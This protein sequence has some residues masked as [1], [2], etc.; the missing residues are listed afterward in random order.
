M[1]HAGVRVR[2]AND[3]IHGAMRGFESC[4]LYGEQLLSKVLVSACGYKRSCSLNRAR[5]SF[6]PVTMSG[7]IT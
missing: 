5:V 6:A 4:K 2:A 7:T 3:V 1:R